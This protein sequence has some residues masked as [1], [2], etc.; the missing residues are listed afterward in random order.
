MFDGDALQYSF[1]SVCASYT[2]ARLYSVFGAT[3]HNK[4]GCLPTSK[5]KFVLW[6]E[7]SGGPRPQQRMA[8]RE[9]GGKQFK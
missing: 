4:L 9:I 6:S 2:E 8:G 3:R 7:A 1:L 5:A